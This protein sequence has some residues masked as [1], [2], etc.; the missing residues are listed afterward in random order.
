MKRRSDEFAVSSRWG[1][2]HARLRWSDNEEPAC[3]SEP[4][5]GRQEPRNPDW[6]E[7]LQQAMAQLIRKLEVGR[8]QH[9]LV[10]S[11]TAR[12]TALEERARQPAPVS[13][14][15]PI[16][17]FEPQ[18]Y[19]LLKEIKV[20]VQATD[21]DEYVATFFDANINVSG[22]NE[23]SAVD[24]LKEALIARFELYSGLTNSKLGREPA[25]QLAVLQ[26]FIQKRG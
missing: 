22:C 6:T 13:I 9:A 17:T 4:S 16:T 23:V 20:V 12:V 15:V 8:R 3:G 14:I 24:N 25:R 26:T 11:L 1:T 2:H 7:S 5:L 19:E 18:P 21:E 10:T